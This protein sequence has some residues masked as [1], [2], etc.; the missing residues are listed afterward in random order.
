M[1]DMPD[2]NRDK[3]VNYTILKNS[4]VIISRSWVLLLHYWIE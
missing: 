2:Y 1:P 3:Y 4:C